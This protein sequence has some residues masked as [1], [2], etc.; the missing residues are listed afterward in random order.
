MI[1]PHI[2]PLKWVLGLL[3][4]IFYIL[5]L[6]AISRNHECFLIIQTFS[7]SKKIFV[8]L[9]TFDHCLYYPVSSSGHVF[10]FLMVLKFVSFEIMQYL[11]F[12]DFQYFVDK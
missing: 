11:Y 3:S 10:W 1:S 4:I 8:H 9:Q 6:I 5:S 2:H 12:Y 7:F